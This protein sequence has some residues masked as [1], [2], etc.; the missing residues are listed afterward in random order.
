MLS[1]KLILLIITIWII[2]AAISHAI[3]THAMF[4]T[5]ADNH[6]ALNQMSTRQLNEFIGTAAFFIASVNDAVMAYSIVFSSTI[7]L[8]LIILNLAV[9]V[10]SNTLLSLLTKQKTLQWAK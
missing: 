6:L 7:I 1:L 8:T 10:G 5:L 4:I 3:G 2:N 9:F